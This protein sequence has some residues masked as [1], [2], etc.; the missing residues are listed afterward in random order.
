M[1]A[2]FYSKFTK[3]VQTALAVFLL[4]FC[5]LGTHWIGLAHSVSH[6]D[7]QAQQQSALSKV[8]PDSGFNHSSDACHLF[9][10]LTLAVFFTKSTFEVN[11]HQ[12]Q[13]FAS[14]PTD[15]SWLTKDHLSPYR[16]RAPPSFIL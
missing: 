4:L 7:S 1:V 5:L 3:Q 11:S 12:V 14:I 8:T 16:S 13:R 10:A 2:Y 9:D 6:T 15:P